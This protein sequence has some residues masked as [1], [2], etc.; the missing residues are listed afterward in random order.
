MN[1]FYF[2]LFFVK[3]LYLFI[4]SIDDDPRYC[5]EPGY[6]DSMWSFDTKTN[7]LF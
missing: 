3:I 6:L 1:L 4:S 7:F 5:L 2:F